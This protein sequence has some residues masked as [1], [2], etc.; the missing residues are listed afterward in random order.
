MLS[1]NAIAATRTFNRAFSTSKTVF[2]NPN[3]F[4]QT[5]L[6]GNKSERK[7]IFNIEA[8]D[9][10]NRAISELGKQETTVDI[11]KYSKKFERQGTY[12]PWHLNESKVSEGRRRRTDE[13]LPKVADPY[14]YLSK[15]GEILPRSQTG[16]SAEMQNKLQKAIKR[17]RAFGLIP[18]TNKGMRYFNN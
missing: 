7:F 10:L 2:D 4:N 13:D 18:Y 14:T 3:E 6:A 12:H 11:T 8:N 5:L 9:I 17:A 15:M 1:R 16:L